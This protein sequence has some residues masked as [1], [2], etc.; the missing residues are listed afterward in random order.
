MSIDE[1]Y[2]S[3]A[4]LP[5]TREPL[6]THPKLE[7]NPIRQRGVSYAPV[8][9]TYQPVSIETI[10]T[11]RSGSVRSTLRSEAESV[12]TMFTGGENWF[13]PVPTMI[14]TRPQASPSK[15]R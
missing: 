6:L 7:K 15:C 11:L 10:W 1:I 13:P 2:L 12:D 4:Y 8:S 5:N 3:M 14:T 9:S